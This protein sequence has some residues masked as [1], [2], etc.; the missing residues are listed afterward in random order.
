MVG[1]TEGAHGVPMNAPSPLA[2][3]GPKSAVAPKPQKTRALRTAVQLLPHTA[4]SVKARAP[5]LDTPHVVVA[6]G[7]GGGP[8]GGVV[9]LSALSVALSGRKKEYGAGWIA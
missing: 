4:P 8:N 5:P 2:H 7:D 1:A 3:A 6:V 9:V